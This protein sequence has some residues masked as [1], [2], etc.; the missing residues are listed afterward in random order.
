MSQNIYDTPDFFAGYAKLGRSVQG[1]AGAAEWPTIQTLF[2]PMQ[3]KEVLDLGCGFGW[4][5]RW[6]R[7]AGAARV[8]AQ[9]LSENMLARAR[10]MTDDPAI[11]YARADLEAF[12]M[13]PASFDLVYSSLAFHYIVRFAEMIAG[14]HACLRPG[15][16]LVFSM[17][18]PLY[19]APSQP[20]W[21]E[22]PI[23]PLDGYGQEGPRETDWIAK[24]VIKQHRTI[25]TVVNTLLDAGFTLRRLIE[26]AP[27]AAQIAA[28]PEWAR[29]VH[30]PP[31]LLVA[32]QR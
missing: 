2:P 21:R 7:E 26:W 9:D 11:A 12:E 28:H 27:D 10:E 5:A 29:E 20:A 4:F 17:E 16:H 25:G 31:F 1:L 30:R 32:A 6:A 14:I 23:W 3:G 15:G 13:P 19:T 24:G 18:H 22:G 8:E